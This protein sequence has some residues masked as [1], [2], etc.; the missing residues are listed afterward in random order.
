MTSVLAQI[1][2]VVGAAR[3]YARLASLAPRRPP[4]PETAPTANASLGSRAQQTNAGESR[5]HRS[6]RDQR[7]AAVLGSP[8]EPLGDDFAKECMQGDASA[9][10]ALLELA[11]HRV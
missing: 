3:R 2:A 1:E 11:P 4:T 9:L 5:D 10:R 6:S 8:R 7:L